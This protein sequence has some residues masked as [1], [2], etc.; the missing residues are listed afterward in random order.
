MSALYCSALSFTITTHLSLAPSLCV[1]PSFLLP[2]RLQAK[3]ASVP[4]VLCIWR[5]TMLRQ[6]KWLSCCAS[7]LLDDEA[8]KEACVVK[9]C[10]DQEVKNVRA[11]TMCC[12]G[13]DGVVHVHVAT[14]Y[15][16][17]TFW[18]IPLFPLSSTSPPD[19]YVHIQMADNELFLSS[20]PHSL[21]CL[22]V[23][24]HSESMLTSNHMT[25]RALCCLPRPSP[26]ICLSL[27]QLTRK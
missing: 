27:W 5:V 24:Y 11:C 25:T 9:Q 26:S 20:R 22:C 3:S 10:L 18:V 23:I 12:S 1:A 4:R 8:I 21:S 7:F 6:E 16:E 2:C 19:I 14:N 15:N 17:Q 13:S